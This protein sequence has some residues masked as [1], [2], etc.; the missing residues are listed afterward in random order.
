NKSLKIAY[1]ADWSDG[2][3]LI[4]ISDPTAP[5]K[6]TEF[7]DGGRIHSVEI[8]GDLVFLANEDRGLEITQIE[9]R[10]KIEENNNNETIVG[11]ELFYILFVLTTILVITI[12]TRKKHIIIKN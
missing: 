8:V 2:L 7:H 3:E 9:E 11:F 10:D 1:L 6:L 12:W 5:I 4:N